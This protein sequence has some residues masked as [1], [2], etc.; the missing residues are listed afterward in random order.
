MLAP[1]QVEGSLVGTH[2]VAVAVNDLHT[3]A[4]TREGK[5]FLWGAAPWHQSLIL[6][7]NLVPTLVEGALANKRVIGVSIGKVH[8]V[9]VIDAGECYTWGR[10]DM[11]K[12]GHGDT[13]NH[14]TPTL[15]TGVLLGK[16]V[17][18]VAAGRTHTAVVTLEGDLYT[19]GGGSVEEAAEL[20]FYSDLCK[21]GHGPIDH[22]EWFYL[23]RLVSS[24]WFVDPSL[25]VWGRATHARFPQEFRDTVRALLL[26]MNRSAAA[27]VV[28]ETANEARAPALWV[29][30]LVE[31]VT[32]EPAIL[33]GLSGIRTHVLKTV[34]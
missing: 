10:E 6:P 16:R 14:F 25:L 4:V 19:W 33:A 13:V 29:E 31:V 11:G 32:S 17:V 20:G 24:Q 12:L 21:L 3:A 7:S 18:E 2:V 30:G 26:A 34:Y 28:D 9:A 27:K 23:P 15:V 1:K 8:M 5:L 22:E